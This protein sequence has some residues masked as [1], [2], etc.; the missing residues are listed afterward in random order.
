MFVKD[1]R[2]WHA[3]LGESGDRERLFAL[4]R[5]LEFLRRNIRYADGRTFLMDAYACPFSGASLGK[6]TLIQISSRPFITECLE[7][8]P[9][10]PDRTALDALR[11]VQEGVAN[12]DTLPSRFETTKGARLANLGLVPH[13][14]SLY[15][16]DASPRASL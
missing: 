3:G 16:R 6:G 5:C 2:F 10:P 4:D 13:K 12:V 11:I 1:E 8:F 7:K 15:H 9:A 14:P